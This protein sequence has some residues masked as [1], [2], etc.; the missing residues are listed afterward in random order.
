MVT[1]ERVLDSLADATRR[2]VLDLVRRKPSSVQE[3]ADQLPISR[4]AV[5]QHLKILKDAE[6]VTSHPV[7]TRRVYTVTTDGFEVL[8]QWL[9]VVWRDALSSFA[10]FADNQSQRFRRQLMTTITDV[11]REITVAGTPERAFDLFTNHMAEWWPADHHL[12]GSPVVAMTV[13]P[14]IGGRIYDSCEDGS[15]SV[16]GQV[17]EWDPPAGLPSRG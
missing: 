2:E 7:G 16:W 8:R 17:T 12:A 4:P 1:Y 3:I 15:E 13:E 6:I 14:R 10:D 11:R 5:S 9:D